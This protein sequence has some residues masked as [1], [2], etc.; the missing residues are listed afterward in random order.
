MIK[1]I[2]ELMAIHGLSAAALAEKIGIS[3][4][5]MSNILT[6]KNNPSLDKAIKLLYVYS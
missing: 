5:A 1:R 6:G 3:A 2:K 4:V